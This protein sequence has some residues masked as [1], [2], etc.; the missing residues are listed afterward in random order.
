MLRISAVYFPGSGFD[1]PSSSSTTNMSRRIGN[2]T[3]TRLPTARDAE[4]N[5]QKFNHSI[6]VCWKIVIQIPMP[7]LLDQCD[8]AR[9]ILAVI[10]RSIFNRDFYLHR[11][12]DIFT[13]FFSETIPD[14]FK[15]LLRLYRLFFL[16]Y[17]LSLGLRLNKECRWA[18]IDPSNPFPVV[19]QDARRVQS[20]AMLAHQVILRIESEGDISRWSDMLYDI[21]EKTR[22][23]GKQIKFLVTSSE[24]LRVLSMEAGLTG[25]SPSSSLWQDV[26]CQMHCWWWRR[27]KPDAV[28]RYRNTYFGNATYIIS[29]NWQHRRQQHHTGK[30]TY[31]NIYIYIYLWHINASRIQNKLKIYI[32][33]RILYKVKVGEA[34]YMM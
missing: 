4:L 17:H 30:L 27:R 8:D 13:S 14:G 9:P 7:K 23:L 12:I 15:I 10:Y 1:V 2:E 18:I 19:Q 20:R 32:Q 22:I 25:A 3:R 5:D 31:I 21:K 16:I 11:W 26:L 34:H 6:L 33:N 28:N 29:E 24:V